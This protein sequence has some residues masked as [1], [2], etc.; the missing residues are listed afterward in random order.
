MPDAPVDYGEMWT[1]LGLNLSA[2]CAL[3][4]AIGPM[5]GN[6]YVSQENRPEGMN[7]FDFVISEIHGLRI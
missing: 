7:Y 3:L 2:H 5:Y 4:D 6:A 1:D